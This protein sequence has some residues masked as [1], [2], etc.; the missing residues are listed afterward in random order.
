MT[1]CRNFEEYP[2]QECRVAIVDPVNMR[3]LV[4]S[5]DLESRLPRIS[6]PI[7]SRMAATATEAIYDTFSVSTIQ[8]VNIADDDSQTRLLVHELVAARPRSTDS[9]TL[10]HIAIENLVPGQLSETEGGLLNRLISGETTEFGR[11]ARVGWIDDLF[12]SM[13]YGTDRSEWPEIR[14]LNQGINFSL[15]SVT[16]YDKPTRWFKAVGV[17]NT[18][19][20][21]ITMELRRRVPA[22]LPK[23]LQAIPEWHAWWSEGVIPGTRLDQSCDVDDWIRTLGCLAALQKQLA[24][25]TASFRDAGA[26]TWT[27]LRLLSLLEPFFAD[28]T[29]ASLAQT[30]KRARRLEQ[31][32]L[33]ELRASIESGLSAV[34][35]SG[36][37]DTVNHG[38]IGHGNILIGQ[39]GSVFLDWAGCYIGPP[40]FTSE[41]LIAD[42]DRCYPGRLQEVNLLRRTYLNGWQSHIAP[43]LF[44]T[45]V[46]LAPGLAA[47]AYGVMVW[48]GSLQRRDPTQA[49]PIIRSMLRRTVREFGPVREVVVP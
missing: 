47:F 19:E 34:A 8:L 31:H 2:L 45:T 12:R 49:W 26:E 39:K 18:H 30:T 10:A 1:V 25:S 11:F 37:P 27:C 6:I 40:F 16:Q 44:R 33:D 17:P 9:V 43:R 35:S 41:H 46:T 14:H 29:K 5:D 4:V 7:S 36:L 13:G 32:D 38:D 3:L 21:F 15:L 28:A 22:M 23:I 42:F 24:P 48:H 20:Y